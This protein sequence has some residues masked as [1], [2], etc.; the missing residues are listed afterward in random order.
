MS[1]LFVSPHISK[2][3]KVLHGDLCSS[4]LVETFFENKCLIEWTPPSPKS[5][6]YW[7]SPTASAEEFL[8]VIW[9]AVSKTIVLILPH[10]KLSLQL[11]HCFKSV[12][13]N[14]TWCHRLHFHP[15]PHDEITWWWG[16]SPWK[17]L[18]SPRPHLT[19]AVP[20]HVRLFCD[21]M[22]WGPPGS[23]VR[24]ILLARILEWVAIPFSRRSSQPSDRTQFSC[25]AGRFFTI[26]ATRETCPISSNKQAL[27][28]Q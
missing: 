12:E 17:H 27:C 16:S 19:F 10:I 11:S 21:P 6:V 18:G 24:G 2:S 4:W 3:I 14:S 20:H 8:R 9:K 26:W 1:L 28:L 7:P 5:H 22:G 15:K 25:V 13:G 23:S